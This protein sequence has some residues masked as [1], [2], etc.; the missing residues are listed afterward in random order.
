MNKIINFHN[1][2]DSIWFDMTLTI[3]KSKYDMIGIDDLF[4]YYYEGLNLK[5][6]CHITVD[7]GDETFYDVMFPVLQKH[8]IPASIFV[9]P[10][11]CKEGKNFWFQEIRGYDEVELKKIVSIHTKIDYQI[12]CKYSLDSFLKCLKIDLIWEII[13]AYQQRFNIP[14][15]RAQ[16]MNLNQLIEIDKHGLIVIGAHTE[17]HPILANEDDEKSKKEIEDSIKGLRNVLN[18]DIK[19]FAYPKGIPNID[20]GER[21]IEV[22]HANN[23]KIAF[24]TEPDDF[25]KSNNPL[26]VPRYGLTRGSKNFVKAKLMFGKN[27]E[28]IRNI[29][30]KSEIRERMEISKIIERIAI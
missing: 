11:I 25:S 8:N 20:F 4:S 21:E 22:L 12:V 10:Y 19:Y 18:H 2:E 7:D 15:K 6:A 14:A 9:S 5:N 27:W 29:R 3:L 16:N 28:K 26:N 1:V 13:E 24:S 23:C 30:H 17:V